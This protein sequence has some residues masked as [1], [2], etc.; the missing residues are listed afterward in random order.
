MADDTSF[1]EKYVIGRLAEIGI[2]AEKLP[3]IHARKSCDLLAVDQHDRYLIEVKRRR[4]DETIQKLLRDTGR[5]GLLHHPAGYSA[6]TEKTM[7]EAVKQLDAISIAGWPFKLIWFY[8]DPQFRDG[9]TLALQVHD[10]A[11]GATNLVRMTTV[12]EASSVH[13]YFFHRSIFHTHP[14]LSGVVL[15]TGSHVALLVNPFAKRLAE[16][17]R[18]GFHLWFDKDE[19]GVVDPFRLEAAGVAFVAD[20]AIDRRNEHA[21]LSYLKQKYELPRW[22]LFHLPMIHHSGFV[23]LPFKNAK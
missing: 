9:H 3:R 13:C 11:F 17:R 18:T 2:R 20:C 4:S 15:D 8:I 21:V 22:G 23:S 19:G 16:F 5:T 7:R 10:T 6:S 12:G 1:E 14:Q